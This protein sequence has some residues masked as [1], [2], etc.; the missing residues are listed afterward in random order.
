MF[1]SFEAKV[2]FSHVGPHKLVDIVKKYIGSLVHCSKQRPLM[3][4]ATVVSEQFKAGKQTL[5]G[6]S[7]KYPSVHLR[8]QLTVTLSA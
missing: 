8:T 7:A 6:V 2:P 3:G 4:S 1:V 5:L